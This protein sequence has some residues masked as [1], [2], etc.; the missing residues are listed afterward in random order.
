LP[1]SIRRPGRPMGSST[2][3]WLW[4]CRRSWPCI[5]PWPKRVA[6]RLRRHRQVLARPVPDEARHDG[7]AVSRH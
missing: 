2:W 7:A 6:H 4:R 5:R 3:S 1:K